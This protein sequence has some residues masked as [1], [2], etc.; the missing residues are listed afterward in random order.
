MKIPRA[1]HIKRSPSKSVSRKLEYGLWPGVR[2]LFE[3]A[4]YINPASIKSPKFSER[5]ASL[6][7]NAADLK[8]G[9]NGARKVPCILTLI[10]LHEY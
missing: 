4:Q 10:L 5:W 7:V 3:H 9:F 8:F 6:A 1:K 2:I